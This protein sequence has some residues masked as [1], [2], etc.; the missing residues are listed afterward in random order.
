MLATWETTWIG[1]QVGTPH[2]V[3]KKEVAESV[4]SNNTFHGHWED[5]KLYVEADFWASDDP[6]HLKRENFDAEAIDVDKHSQA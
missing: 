2:N 6:S 4:S 3:A 1:L 5:G